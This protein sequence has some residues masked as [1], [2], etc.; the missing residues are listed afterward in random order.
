METSR[1]IIMCSLLH[2]GADPDCTVATA[3]TSNNYFISSKCT[4]LPTERLR[5]YVFLNFNLETDH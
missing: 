5:Q 3:Q 4:V 1:N 2:V